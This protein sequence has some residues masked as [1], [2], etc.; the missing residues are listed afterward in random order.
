MFGLKK[1]PKVWKNE[2][3]VAI[4]KVQTPA[5]YGD[6]RP[7]SMSPL[8]SKVLESVVAELTIEETGKNWRP[9]QHGG[10]K[11]FSTDHVLVEAW[12]QILR[13]L[14]K[15][16]ENKAV[17]FTALDFSKS[18]SRCS[19]QQILKSFSKVGTSHWL[20]NMHAAFL[21]GKTM[22]VNRCDRR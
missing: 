17:V 15:P 19:H 11:G 3:V 21:S 1:G 12:D 5:G 10:V 22:A 9:N 4:P 7:I 16:G 20:L 2:M 8:W 6:L 14:D 18:F 13:G